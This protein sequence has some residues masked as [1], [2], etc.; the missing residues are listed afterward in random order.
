MFNIA[1]IKLAAE[2]SP[3]FLLWLMIVCYFAEQ[4][5]ECSVSVVVF[6]VLAPGD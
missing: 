1:E 3:T 5:L 4:F 6:C 2:I